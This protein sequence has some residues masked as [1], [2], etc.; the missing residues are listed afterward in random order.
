[1]GATGLEHPASS[2][3]KTDIPDSRGAKSSASPDAGDADPRLRR[4][5][6]TWKGLPEHVRAAIMAL[7]TLG[8][9]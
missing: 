5:V 7:A 2:S 6:H 1:M 3:G 9:Q 4:L 8:E